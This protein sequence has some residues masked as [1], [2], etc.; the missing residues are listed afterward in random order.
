MFTQNNSQTD[1]ETNPKINPPNLQKENNTSQILANSSKLFKN[2]SAKQFFYYLVLIGCLFALAIAGFTFLRANLVR[3]VFPDVDNY[4]YS[5]YPM[6]ANRCK[7]KNNPYSAYPMMPIPEN[8]SRNSTLSTEMPKAEFNSPE[9]I[10][11]C[12]K[13]IKEEK[14][15]QINRQY[16]TDMLNSI[17]TI[18]ITSIILV[19][20][21]KFFKQLE[22]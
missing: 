13:K 12:E 17:L 20:N 21:I 1:L 11:V 18:I 16:Q 6:D 15:F 7:Y 5:S 14:D 4:S 10:K 8:S 9:E 3:F 19:G 2:N 22:V